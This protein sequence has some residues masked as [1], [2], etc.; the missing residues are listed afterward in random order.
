MSLATIGVAKN[1]FWTPINVESEPPE[2]KIC[3]SVTLLYP[4]IIFV[5]SPVCTYV[6][7]CVYYNLCLSYLYFRAQTLSKM[8][9]LVIK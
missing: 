6:C 2:S 8:Q 5:C 9:D 1:Y 7:L 4:V 3:I